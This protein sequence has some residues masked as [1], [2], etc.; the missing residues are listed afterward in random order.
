[1]QPIPFHVLEAFQEKYFFGGSVLIPFHLGEE[2]SD[3][4]IYRFKDQNVLFKICFLGQ[5][6]RRQEQLRFGKRLDFLYFLFSRGVHVVQPFLSITG[7]NFEAVEDELGTWVAY[8]MQKVEGTTMSPKVWEP[9]FVQKWGQTIGALHRVT[10]DYP[11]WERTVDPATG[12]DLLSWEWELKGFYDLVDEPDIQ[13]QWG[14]IHEELRTLP[15]QRDGFGMI[16]ND[17]HLWNIRWVEGQAVLLDFETVNH[18]WFAYDLTTAC[19]HVVA[20]LS[21]GLMRPMQHPEW[22]GDFL[23]EFLVGYRRENDLSEAW[24]DRLNLFFSYRRL[25]L[26]TVLPG[27]RKAN[28][29]LQN[30][31]K[32]MILERPNIMRDVRF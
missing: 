30:A 14:L 3:G 22:L 9:E 8:A 23:R 1:M 7:R 13:A 5:G 25:L 10:Q 32:K 24:L 21:G 17:P 4:A 16:H 2:G 28:P 19:Q 12:D 26:Y 6:D 15:V 31:W 27:W 29:G 18:F 20:M 11:N